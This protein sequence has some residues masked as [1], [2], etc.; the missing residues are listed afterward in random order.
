MGITLES[1]VLGR[2]EINQSEIYAF[3]SGIPGFEDQKRF[4]VVKPEAD[5]PFAYLQSMD[6][7]ELVLLVADPFLFFSDYDFDISDQTV[8][9][10]KIERPEQV[11]VW[12]VVTV[13]D[14]LEEAT[15]NLLA[16]IVVNADAKIG[17]QTVLATGEY[18]TKHALFPDRYPA[19][20]ASPGGANHV[21]SYP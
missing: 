6:R 12:C 20:E 11:E 18:R 1:P 10:L 15:A 14:S 16:P 17:K 21:G 5:S 8:S 13:P 9:E 3:P 19:G 4:I 2:L 7:P